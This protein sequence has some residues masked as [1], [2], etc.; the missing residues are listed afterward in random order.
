VRHVVAVADPGHAEAGKV[1]TVPPEDLADRL[2]VRQELAG[3][4]L[5]REAVDHRDPRVARQGLDALL[6]EGP[7]HDRVRVAAEH[8]RGVLEGLSAPELRVARHERDGQAA[9]LEHAHLERHAGSG[10]GLLEHDRHALSGQ[11]SRRVRGAAP[12][13]ELVRAEQDRA[14][15]GA[16]EVE[17]RTEVACHGAR[18]YRVRAAL[19]H[20]PALAVKGLL[21]PSGQLSP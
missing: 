7:V 5:V 3:V 12:G 10:G 16:R 8:P 6:S 21:G 11:R 13:L 20:R 2:E 15:L 1:G 4:E 14:E 9:E 19:A 18:L 17:E